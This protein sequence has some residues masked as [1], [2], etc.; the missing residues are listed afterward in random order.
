MLGEG[1]VQWCVH[2]IWDK[3][4]ISLIG[5]FM[6]RC[7]LQPGAEARST[8]VIVKYRHRSATRCT[9]SENSPISELHPPSL[10]MSGSMSGGPSTS[11]T[12]GQAELDTG[13]AAPGIRRTR[14]GCLI[15]RQRRVKCDET[16]PICG[17]C[18]K[19]AEQCAWDHED[20][21]RPPKRISRRPNTTS[22]EECRVKKVRRDLSFPIDFDHSS[23]APIP[24]PTVASA[25]ADWAS[26]ASKWADLDR[27]TT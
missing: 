1:N 20:G 24:K 7:L 14:T 15:C 5:S 9:P 22:C 10:A 2:R 13:V 3:G 12:L 19:R 8:T 16:K 21:G 6:H 4:Y 17:R 25:A 18:L 27:V 23:D 26:H 11:N